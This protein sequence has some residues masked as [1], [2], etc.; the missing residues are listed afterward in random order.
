[1][2]IATI[3]ITSWNHTDLS[4][5]DR[6]DITNTL[7]GTNPQENIASGAQQHTET[8]QYT[9]YDNNQGVFAGFLISFLRFYS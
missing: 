5:G 3:R 2:Q 7:A 8:Q 9:P 4:R 1:M 6:G